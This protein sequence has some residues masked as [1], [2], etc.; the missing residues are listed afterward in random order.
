MGKAAPMA[1][2]TKEQSTQQQH[3]AA[4]IAIAQIAGQRCPQHAAPQEGSGRQ[5]SL[6]CSQVE[7]RPQ[8]DKGA[9]HHRRIV[10]KEQP[11][12]GCASGDQRYRNEA[13]ALVSQDG[14][15]CGQ[16]SWQSFKLL[17]KES[18]C[19]AQA[20]SAANLANPRIPSFSGV[21]VQAQEMCEQSPLARA[22]RESEF[23]TAE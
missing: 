3:P 8:K 17:R 4:S 23:P 10:A 11:G 9:V 19:P 15:I 20:K 6:K 21:F 12:D 14:W 2:A 18:N 22:H 13:G 7:L 16:V 1:E 5:L